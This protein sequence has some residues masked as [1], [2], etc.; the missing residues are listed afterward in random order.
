ML[1]NSEFM[2]DDHGDDDGDH[3]TATMCASCEQDLPAQGYT[4]GE[5]SELFCKDCVTKDEEGAILCK[6]C[7]EF[8]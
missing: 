5:C 6:T 4:C 8:M 2:D 1:T 7:K 3:E